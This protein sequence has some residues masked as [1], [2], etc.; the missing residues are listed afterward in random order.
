MKKIAKFS[1]QH[2]M[3]LYQKWMCS[4]LAL[5]TN[6]EVWVASVEFTL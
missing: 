2:Y 1:F 3:L 4:I 5:G 6:A